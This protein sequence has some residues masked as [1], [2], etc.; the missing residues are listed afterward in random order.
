MLLPLLFSSFTPILESTYLLGAPLG[1]YHK[2][3]TLKRLNIYISAYQAII[4]SY[5]KLRNTELWFCTYFPQHLK[6]FSVPWHALLNAINVT[7]EK[8]HHGVILVSVN[9][10]CG[11]FWG[12]CL[13]GFHCFFFFSFLAFGVGEQMKKKTLKKISLKCLRCISVVRILHAVNRSTD[14]TRICQFGRFLTFFFGRPL[15]KF[16]RSHT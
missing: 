2:I 1:K 15:S 12:A 14:L 8:I 10:H 6:M 11:M 13:L 4:R 7:Y 5:M 9:D 16:E 3:E